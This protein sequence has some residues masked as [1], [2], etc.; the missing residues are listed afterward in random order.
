MILSD[1][2]AAH[3]DL[4]LGTHPESAAVLQDHRTLLRKV[5]RGYD[6]TGPQSRS[7]GTDTLWVVESDQLGMQP[8]GVVDLGEPGPST[9][10]G[11]DCNP[12]PGQAAWIA[13]PI[14]R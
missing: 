2:L 8:S 4:A 13:R 7:E 14:A 9:R 11:E 1:L 6:R 10:S 12:V 3:T 5:R